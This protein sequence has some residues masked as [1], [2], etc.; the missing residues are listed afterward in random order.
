M[1][2]VYYDKKAVVKFELPN[3]TQS[4]IDSYNWLF[5]EGLKELFDEINPIEDFTGENYI[6][7]FLDYELDE[8]KVDEETVKAKN[9]TYKAP[10]K[11]RIK[12]TDKKTGK[13]KESDVFMGD[14]PL[15]TSC[16]TFIINGIERVIVNQIV[17]SYG[18]LFTADDFN[19]RK[20]FGAKIIPTRGSWLEFE[21]SKKKKNSSNNL[22]K[23][24]WRI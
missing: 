9:L 13:S 8:A 12:L 16:G 4:Q 19:Y 24:N 6:L 20:Y 21:T 5:E 11:I 1:D 18:V 2:R 23:S 3:L 15:M 22:F 10:L 7:E 17:R 14:F